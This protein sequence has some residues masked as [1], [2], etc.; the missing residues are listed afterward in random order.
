MVLTGC[1]NMERAQNAKDGKNRV[2]NRATRQ[3]DKIL[4][5]KHRNF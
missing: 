1:L 3:K 5:R 2:I 4:V